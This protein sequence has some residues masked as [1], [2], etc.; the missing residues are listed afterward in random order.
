MNDLEKF[1]Y[2][3]YWYRKYIGNCPVCGSDKSY[4]MRQYGQKPESW[5]ERV[6]YL[7]DQECYDQ[8][9]ERE[10]LREI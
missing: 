8:C 2:P 3:K 10:A 6:V 5:I 7:S 9:L 1:A 4:K